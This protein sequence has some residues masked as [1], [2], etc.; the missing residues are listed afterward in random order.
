M[1]RKC[2]QLSVSSPTN[3]YGPDFLLVELDEQ[4]AVRIRAMMDALGELDADGVMVLDGR[5]GW[6]AVGSRIRRWRSVPIAPLDH[7]A[8]GARAGRIWS[9]RTPSRC[10]DCRS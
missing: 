9:G 1:K 4:D 6:R 10:T 2:F 3:D 5:P 7:C 8:P